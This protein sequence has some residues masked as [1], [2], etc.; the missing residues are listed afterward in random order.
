MNRIDVQVVI[1]PDSI[2][3]NTEI[4]RVSCISPASLIGRR[5]PE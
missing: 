1:D 4:G 2:G 5:K 3:E